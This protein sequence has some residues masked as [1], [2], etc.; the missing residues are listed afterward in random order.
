M[1]CEEVLLDQA[2]TIFWKICENIRKG[3]WASRRQKEKLMCCGSLENVCMRRLLL[4]YVWLQIK[5]FKYKTLSLPAQNTQ[6]RKM[7]F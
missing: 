7:K 2:W 5:K 3:L 6:N 1:N 4:F